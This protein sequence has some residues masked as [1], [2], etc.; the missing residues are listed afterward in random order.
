[1]KKRIIMILSLMVILT[2]A[3]AGCGSGSGGKQADGGNL[4][5]EENI[6]EQAADQAAVSDGTSGE[7]KQGNVHIIE[8][9]P[10]DVPAPDF[11]GEIDTNNLQNGGITLMFRNTDPD[12]TVRYLQKLRDAGFDYRVDEYDKSMDGIY[13]DE[14][15]NPMIH[16][17]FSAGKGEAEYNDLLGG[18]YIADGYYISIAYT[19]GNEYDVDS[20]RLVSP[21]KVRIDLMWKDIVIREN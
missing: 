4:E 18:Y 10:D 13:M 14:S 6:N 7:E 5:A 12:L 20:G 8:G 11:G 17:F 2:L 21:A 19:D 9:W 16:H 3:L 1:M 15:G